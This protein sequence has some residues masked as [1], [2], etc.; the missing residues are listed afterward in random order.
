MFS[1]HHRCVLLWAAF[2]LAGQT[3]LV[4]QAPPTAPALGLARARQLA[5]E[6]SPEQRAARDALEAS[7]GRMRQAGAFPN[8][9]LALSH[10]RTR[11][12]GEGNSQVIAQFEQP[13]AFGGAR[14]A[15]RDAAASLRQ[16]AQA[17]LDRIGTDLDL[18]VTRAW[19]GALAGDRRLALADRMLVAFDRAVAM[20]AE[21][22]AAGD[23]S[24]LAH[25][26][27]T[28]EAARWTA[29]RAGA[30]LEAREARL[31]LAALIA[32]DPDSIRALAGTPLDTLGPPSRPGPVEVLLTRAHDRRP[33]LRAAR[34]QAEA[35]AAT[36]RAVGRDRV[37]LPTLALGYKSEESAGLDGQFAGFTLGLNLPLPIWDR[38]AGAV[39]AAR[40]DARGDAALA[41][42]L[43][44]RVVRQVLAAWDAWHATEAQR[45]ALAAR[46]GP[47]A[48]AALVAL[49]AAFTEGEISLIE[50]LD[51]QRAFHEAAAMRVALEAES[52]IR[53]A[54]LEH[55]AGGPLTPADREDLR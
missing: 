47:D 16:K 22:L 41:Q 25:R 18:A 21:R 7:E 24:G 28:L 3:V 13:L 37:P 40:A 50:W 5:R 30:A 9:T 15:R 1:Q 26:R 2:A 44:R 49:D 38:S 46:L 35:A 39:R 53:T 33:D 4:A 29:A 54:E 51:A 36:A 31:A 10:E 52:A 17:D 11:R 32:G 45:A 12:D 14:A 42:A 20:N 19:A 48:D 23:V 34:A 6:A 55:A 27:L 8:P 43:E